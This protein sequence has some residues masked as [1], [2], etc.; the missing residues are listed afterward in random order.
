VSISA[1]ILQGTLG[2][3]EGWLA[4][5]DPLLLVKLPPEGFKVVRF[6]EMT[7]TAGENNLTSFEAMLEVFK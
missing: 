6:L 5:D 1:E 7:D 4:I 3:I 2:A